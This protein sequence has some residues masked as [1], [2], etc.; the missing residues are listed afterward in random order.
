MQN[1][2]DTKIKKV[3]SVPQIGLLDTKKTEVG[4]T[5]GGAEGVSSPSS[6][7]VYNGDS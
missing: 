7:V 1:K 5:P 3:W 2:I 4:T 6:S